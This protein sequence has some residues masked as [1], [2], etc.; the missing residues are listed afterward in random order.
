[1]DSA[2]VMTGATNQ[3]TLEHSKIKPTYTIQQLSELLNEY[4]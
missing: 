3:T 1:M 2:L 4:K